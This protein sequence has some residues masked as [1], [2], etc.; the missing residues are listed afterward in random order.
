[1]LWHLNMRPRPK[2]EICFMADCFSPELLGRE[3]TFKVAFEAS[4]L[5]HLAFI[6]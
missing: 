3:L 1:M 6:L 2:I 4:P 5:R